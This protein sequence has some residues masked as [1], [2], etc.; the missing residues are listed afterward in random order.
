MG[1]SHWVLTDVGLM[2][3]IPVSSRRM[4]HLAPESPWAAVWSVRTVADADTVLD[5]AWVANL[6]AVRHSAAMRH[7]GIWPHFTKMISTKGLAVHFGLIA[8]NSH[9]T[10]L[11]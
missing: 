9:R 3:S 6:T 5:A 11:H 10:P 8:V 4:Q 1:Q 2:I 7:S